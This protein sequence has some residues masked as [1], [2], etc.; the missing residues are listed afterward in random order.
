VKLI[1]ALFVVVGKLSEKDRSWENT[2]PDVDE[3]DMSYG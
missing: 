3:R 2:L 1:I